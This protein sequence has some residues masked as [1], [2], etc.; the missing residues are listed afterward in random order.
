M[1]SNQDN[2]GSTEK[3]STSQPDNWPIRGHRGREGAPMARGALLDGTRRFAKKVRQKIGGFVENWF[4]RPL[5][6]GKSTLESI[7]DL[8]R[9]YFKSEEE[10]DAEA[11][12][13]TKDLMKESLGDELGTNVRRIAKKNKTKSNQVKNKPSKN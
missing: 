11:E 8:I 12:D 4:L 5:K 2:E 6:Y 13:W 1:V 10:K 9:F 7:W 3:G